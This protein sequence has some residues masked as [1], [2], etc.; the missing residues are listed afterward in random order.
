MLTGRSLGQILHDVP[1]ALNQLLHLISLFVTIIFLGFILI[2]ILAVLLISLPSLAFLLFGSFLKKG[3]H[4]R[5]EFCVLRCSTTSLD[6]N[7]LRGR[8]PSL[9]YLPTQDAGGQF[10]LHAAAVGRIHPQQELP[11]SGERDGQRV[12]YFFGVD[13]GGE[14]I[15]KCDFSGYNMTGKTKKIKYLTNNTLIFWVIT[16]VLSNDI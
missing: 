16:T 9:N 2:F 8:R 7:T 4:R 13:A 6:T 5:H 11:A 15:K 12:K 10:A 3:P 14:T 1:V